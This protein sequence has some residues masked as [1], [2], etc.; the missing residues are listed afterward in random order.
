M[1]EGTY[2]PFFSR[3]LEQEAGVITFFNSEFR[4]EDSY[5]NRAGYLQERSFPQEARE[6]LVELNR[7]L[8]V[9]P[10]GNWEEKVRDRRTLFVITGQQPGLFA[11]PLLVLYKGL[12]AVRLARRLEALLRVPVQ[13]LFWVATEDHNV[14]P[15]LRSFVPLPDG[16]IGRIRISCS[17]NGLPAGLV[18]LDDR[19]VADSLRQLSMRGDERNH[20]EVLAWLSS[21]AHGG[22]NN[23]AG[24]FMQIM[25]HLCAAEGLILFDPLQAAARN[26]YIPMLLQTL[27]CSSKAHDSI[28]ITE[29]ALK[30]AGYPLQVQRRGQESFI[31][32]TWEN[33]RYP[34]LREG[35]HYYTPQ[36]ELSLSRSE[37]LTLIMEQPSVFSPGVL[38]RPLFQDALFPT[39]AY[40]AG[41]GEL[42]Y[43]AQIKELYPMF[44]MEMPILYPRMGVTLLEPS[45]KK[46]VSEHDISLDTLLT[47]LLKEARTQGS[48]NA[49]R[50]Q[51]LCNNLWPRFS[52]QE[53]VFNI[54]PYLIAYGFSFWN[55][56][57]HKFEGLP[58]H[59]LYCWEGDV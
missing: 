12:T 49:W 50:L 6:L 14:G 31:M 5:I 24:W 53:R 40:V 48:S 2:P 33:R 25:S 43:F 44:H 51:P 27:E 4:D 11:G 20:D 46:I 1:P 10:P 52:P 35:E 9:Q 8:M 22:K 39:L 28:A 36:G 29:A 23:L 26:L 45:L 34:L 17:T 21:A 55:D 54:V 47:D 16:G 41:P 42:A 56:F 3:Y 19:D 38:F 32:I 18:S 57:R 7:G 15:L 30:A 58:G 13:P 37:L 59:Y